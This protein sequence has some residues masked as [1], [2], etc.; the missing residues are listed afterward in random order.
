MNIAVIRPATDAFDPRVV[1]GDVGEHYS[2][3]D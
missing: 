2:R 3:S 1:R